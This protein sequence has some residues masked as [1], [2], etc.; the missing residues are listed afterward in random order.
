MFL[1]NRQFQSFKFENFSYLTRDPKKMGFFRKNSISNYIQERRN[2]IEFGQTSDLCISKFLDP[3]QNGV[4]FAT[5]LSSISQGCVY[6]AVLQICPFLSETNFR[7]MP[8]PC[9]VVYDRN[10]VSVSATETKIKF[11]YRFRGQN[12]FCLNLNFPPF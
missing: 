9:T 11:R 2:V 6:L 4:L 1:F 8:G 12:F 5:V 7:F 10:L 3:I